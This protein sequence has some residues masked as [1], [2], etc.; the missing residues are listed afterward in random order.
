MDDTFGALDLYG[1]VLEVRHS[2]N[3][4]VDGKRE[5]AGRVDAEREVGDI[6]KEKESWGENCAGLDVFPV[7]YTLAIA[8]SAT[9]I[10]S[11]MNIGKGKWHDLRN[12]DHRPLHKLPL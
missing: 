2:R 10:W 1:D 12:G 3:Y 8:L 6:G 11:N 9:Y 4:V 5:A 7:S